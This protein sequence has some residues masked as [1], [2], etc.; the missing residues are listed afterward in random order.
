M[1]TLT[2]TYDGRNKTA[3]CIVEMLRS[4][5][6]FQVTEKPAHKTGIEQALEDVAA[7]RVFHAL[8]GEDLIRQCLAD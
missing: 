7:G 3:R 5:D 1:A 2:L 6:V 4:L 8:N